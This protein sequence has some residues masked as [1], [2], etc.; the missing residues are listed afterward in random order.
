[1]ESDVF[2]QDIY[3]TEERIDRTLQLLHARAR[4]M[5]GSAVRWMFVLLAAGVVGAAA[6]AQ[7]RRQQKRRASARQTPFDLPQRAAGDRRLR[8]RSIG[9]A[10][11]GPEPR[12]TA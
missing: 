12:T 8:L 4:Q 1:M 6:L 11:G 5:Q 10:R 3:C 9:I 2:L 7:W